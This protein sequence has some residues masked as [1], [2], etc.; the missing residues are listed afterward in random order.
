M[1][2]RPALG[3]SPEGAIKIRTF[4]DQ[5]TNSLLVSFAQVGWRVEISVPVGLQYA[6]VS[7]GMPGTAP[8]HKHP[9]PFDF[10]Y[11]PAR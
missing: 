1:S 7:G 11:G 2:P 9:H 5:R 8:C 6:A 3:D 10:A 4:T